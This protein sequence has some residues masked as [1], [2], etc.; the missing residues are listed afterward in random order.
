MLSYK[1]FKDILEQAENEW[2]DSHQ[3]Y[4]CKELYLFFNPMNEN[5]CIELLF[6]S[7]YFV[8]YIKVAIIFTSFW[9]D[10]MSF[11]GN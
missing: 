9:E 8:I 11:F 10:F 1:L 5:L 3:N 7:L 2:M 4:C 6:Y